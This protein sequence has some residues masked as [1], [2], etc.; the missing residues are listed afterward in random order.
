M[1]PRMGISIMKFIKNMIVIF[2][3]HKKMCVFFSLIVIIDIMIICHN[4]ISPNT[5]TVKKTI[6]IKT[7]Y[8]ITL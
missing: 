1:V 7:H 2:N 8:P 3:N 4:H 6:S 5:K